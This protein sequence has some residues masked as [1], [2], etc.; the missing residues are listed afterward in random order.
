M[1]RIF[2]ALILLGAW[3]TASFV[4]TSAPP[5]AQQPAKSAA[6]A[7]TAA[8]AAKNDYSNGDNWLCRP[9]RQDACAVDLATTVVSA[10]GKLTGGDVGGR[11]ERAHRLFLGLSDGLA[12]C[13]RQ[14]RHD[15][16]FRRKRS[17]P[18]AVR[19]VRLEVPPV[20]ADVP[21]GNAYGAAG[22]GDRHSD[23]GGSGDGV[24]GC[25]RRLELL[26]GA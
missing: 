3:G 2:G 25:A 26:F 13:R 19:A 23:S 24:S 4:P 12:G 11:S 6:T 18:R 10:K 5:A 7:A 9:D 8:T 20:C 1:R 21:A 22:G 17:D 15:S 14:Q 16:R